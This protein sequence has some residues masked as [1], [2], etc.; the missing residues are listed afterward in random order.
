MN[1]HII[2]ALPTFCLKNI[3][4]YSLI[5][6]YHQGLYI[7]EKLPTDINGKI[8]ISGSNLAHSNKSDDKVYIY[9][10]RYNVLHT[11]A[12][13]NCDNFNNYKVYMQDG[14]PIPV[15]GECEFCRCQFPHHS[16][17]VPIK[18]LITHQTDSQNGNKIKSYVFYIDDTS[19][20]SFEC[21]KAY[22]E[23]DIDKGYQLSNPHYAG[24]LTILS[25][26]FQL[27]YPDDKELK[28][29]PD[30]KLMIKHGGSLTIQ[31]ARDM[32]HQYKKLPD[33]INIPVKYTYEKY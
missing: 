20:C 2:G 25:Q 5:Y 18:Q 4:C 10:D 31:E 12:T 1:S 30:R 13:T 8:K 15:G 19:F 23:K 27:M 14:T 28:S 16:L 17:G 7:N 32:K 11:I 24:S 6:Q 26:M 9:R 33:V 21:A 29:A 3:D 22:I